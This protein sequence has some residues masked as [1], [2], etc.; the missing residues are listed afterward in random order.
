[1][2][3]QMRYVDPSLSID[4]LD[5]DAEISARG[6]SVEEAPNQPGLKVRAKRQQ[7]ANNAVDTNIRDA[8]DSRSSASSDVC[9]F[10]C[11]ILI[12][13]L[14]FGH[15]YKTLRRLFGD[16]SNDSGQ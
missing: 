7:C 12:L 6:R 16:G 2:L 10:H 4:T 13:I 9:T 1:M 15:R 5:T 8:V 3:I 14:I 11:T